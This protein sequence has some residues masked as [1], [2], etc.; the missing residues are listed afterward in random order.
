ML[1]CCVRLMQKSL[2]G[3]NWHNHAWREQIK[4][5]ATLLQTLARTISSFDLSAVTLSI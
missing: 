4:I 1:H 3:L 2:K 5:E